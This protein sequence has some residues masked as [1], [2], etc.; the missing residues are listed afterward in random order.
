MFWPLMGSFYWNVA[1]GGMPAGEVEQD[2]EGIQTMERLG[3][4]MAWLLKTLDFA[5]DAVPPPVSESRRLFSYI[6]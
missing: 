4:K 5:R 3:K 1:H 6:R 2:L